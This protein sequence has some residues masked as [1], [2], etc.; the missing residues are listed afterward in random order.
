MSAAKVQRGA[1]WTI[2]VIAF[3]H[4]AVTFI[5]YDALSLAALWFVGSGFALLLIGGLNV[6][7]AHLGDELQSRLRALR[8][9]TLV[10]NACGVALGGLF[11]ALTSGTQPQGPVLVV[12]FGVSAICQ[13]QRRR[14]GRG[15]AS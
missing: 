15:A 3:V 6:V 1:G 12:L 8:V 4:L 11:I 13:L 7:T 2:V 10:A 5:D 9:L 14:S